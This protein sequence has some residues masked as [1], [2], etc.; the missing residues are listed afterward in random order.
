MS[1][2]SI[3]VPSTSP[4]PARVLQ[5]GSAER[6][7]AHTNTDRFLDPSWAEVTTLL[8]EYW[9]LGQPLPRADVIFNAI[10]DPDASA[11]ALALASTLTAQTRVP[12]INPPALVMRTGRAEAPEFFSGIDSLHVPR[13]LRVERATLASAPQQ[14]LDNAGLTFPFLLRALG[15]HNGANFVMVRGENDVREQAAALPGDELLA[16]EFVD[17]RGADGLV[18]KYRAIAVDGALFPAHLAVGTAWKLHYFSAQMDERE[19]AE[20]AR[21]LGD[22]RAYLGERAFAALGEIAR[23]MQLGYAGID[24]GIARDGR[25]LLFEA[26]AS[27]TV[28][29]PDAAPETEYRR[30]A[31]LRI[32]AAAREMMRTAA[33]TPRA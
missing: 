19:R 29:L 1:V 15:F 10:A 25:A 31:V 32:D 26:N 11:S 30:A 18:R 12:L 27:M 13:N 9:P 23:R 8:V 2:P 17:A 21:Y 14:T 6:G 33:A 5:L 7:A 28:F 3:T 16:I 24:F 4:H 20:E 22:M